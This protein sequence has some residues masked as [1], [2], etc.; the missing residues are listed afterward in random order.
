MKK[1]LF[2]FLVLISTNTMKS[3]HNDGDYKKIALDQLKGTLVELEALVS[4]LSKEDLAYVPK[5]GGWSVLNCLE[6]LAFVEPRLGAKIKSMVSEN[7]L[8][9]DKNLS[10]NDWKVI[11]KVTDRTKK[12]ITP[13]PFRPQPEMKDKDKDYFLAQL[14][15]DRQDI[16]DF[17]EGTN[18]DLRHLFGPYPYGEADGIQQVLVLA[19]HMYRH[20]MQ[21]KETIL[22][23]YPDR[24]ETARL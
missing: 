22:E 15:N 19:S 3:Q 9:P 11:A 24:D 7:K 23:L 4:D 20:T 5:D 14:K 18:A 8:D 12:V 21:I 6:H 16:I 17:I 2:L 1:T 13:E 10:A